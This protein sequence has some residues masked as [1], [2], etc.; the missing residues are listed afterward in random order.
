MSENKIQ[1]CQ[2][3][4]NSYKISVKEWVENDEKTRTC[5]KRYKR[6]DIHLQ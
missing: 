3:G 2:T 5:N 1:L 4:L 6:R